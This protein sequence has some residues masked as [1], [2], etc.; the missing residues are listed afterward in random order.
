M[1][2]TQQTQQTLVIVKPDG[3]SKG[4]SGEVVGRFEK[5]GLKAVTMEMLKLDRSFVSDFYAH[6]KTKIPEKTLNATLDFM[7]SGMVVM[8]IFE[9]EDAIK[10]ARMVCGPT[11]PA[12]A[13]AGT[14]RGD[15]SND[16]LIENTKRGIATRNV[17]HASSSV[18]DALKEIAMAKKI[19]KSI[20]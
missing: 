19:M 3:V 18:E 6:L 14:I 1:S 20:K 16:D 10:K 2:K 5:A 7:T 12:Q 17:V 13:P 8:A 11:N 15:F 4:I 9:G